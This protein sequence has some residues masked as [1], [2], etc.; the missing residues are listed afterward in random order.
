[1]IDKFEKHNEKISDI[2]KTLNNSNK[3]FSL[4][5]LIIVIAIMAVA[6]GFLIYS[7]S[8]LNSG[9]AKKAAKDVYNQLTKVQRN[10]M[11]MS[12][13]WSLEIV[14]ESGTNTIY[15]YKETDDEGKVLQDS[16]KLGSR[17]E[18]T[19]NKD[20]ESEV[21]IESG[22]RIVVTFERSTGKLQDVVYKG[23]SIFDSEKKNV[24]ITAT[25]KGMSSNHIV[26]MIYA[27]GKIISDN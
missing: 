20:G 5:E 19:F 2:R 8:V 4:I 27:T 9:D 14:N 10:T 17:I 13:K 23:V 15:V 22:Q 11:T 24:Y 18:L 25:G 16:V 3:G 1:M 26:K 12:G 21:K 7:I 6:T